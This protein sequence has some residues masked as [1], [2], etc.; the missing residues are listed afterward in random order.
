MS[1]LGLVVCLLAV[2]LSACNGQGNTITK[3]QAVQIAWETL[4]PYT[5]SHN[6]ANWRT[7]EARSLR[8]DNLPEVFDKRRDLYCFGGRALAAEDIRPDATYWYVLLEPRL[9][10]PPPEI[11]PLSPTAPPR[12]PEPFARQAH[13]LIDASDGRA[14]A[15]R[16][17]CVVY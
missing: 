1:R 12:I 11:T 3:E 13:L 5:S 15:F 14:A 7:L 2:L 4:E 8:G 6:Q 9:A 17:G 10:T 16:L